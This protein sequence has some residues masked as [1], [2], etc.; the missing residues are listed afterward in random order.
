MA[1]SNLTA[2]TK[3]GVYQS[4]IK[5]GGFLRD[6]SFAESKDLSGIVEIHYKLAMDKEHKDIVKI[7]DLNIESRKMIFFYYSKAAIFIPAT[8]NPS[9]AKFGMLGYRHALHKG[10]LDDQI[11]LPVETLI[12]EFDQIWQAIFVDYA[13][14]GNLVDHAETVKRVSLTNILD[15]YR[16]GQKI[17]KE[18]K[19][20]EELILSRP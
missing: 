20:D 9:F 19:A 2:E 15:M 17:I 8:D 4:Q 11:D 1:D 3:N 5:I 6:F 18:E 10:Q 7:M 16:P 12:W 14:K 13:Q